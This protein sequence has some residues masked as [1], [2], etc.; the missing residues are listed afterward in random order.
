MKNQNDK[1]NG[2]IS[3]IPGNK[4]RIFGLLIGVAGFLGGTIW[5]VRVSPTETTSSFGI[6][7]G[8]VGL[9]LGVAGLIGGVIWGQKNP[10]KVAGNKTKIF[11]LLIGIAGFLGGTIWGLNA[12]GLWKSA[13]IFGNPMGILG[14]TLGI[15]GLISGTICSMVSSIKAKG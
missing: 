6:A 2:N 1:K 8:I 14:L 7:M 9:T 10:A 13:E 15:I 11:G 12:S 3:K 4:T 5:G